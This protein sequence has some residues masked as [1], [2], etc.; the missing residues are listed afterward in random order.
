MWAMANAAMPAPLKALG[1]VFNSQPM[2]RREDRLKDAKT[3]AERC[4]RDLAR[5]RSALERKE[6]NLLAQVRYYATKGDYHKA[7]VGSVMIAT[8]A[9]LMVS[10]HKVSRAEIEALKGI[11]YANIEQDITSTRTKGFKYAQRMS[12]C[13]EIETTLNDGLDEVYED[14]ESSRKRREYFD[15][16]ADHPGGRFY[17]QPKQDSQAIVIHFRLYDPI[18]AARES[19]VGPSGENVDDVRQVRFPSVPSIPNL[20]RDKSSSSPTISP[21]NDLSALY[22]SLPPT[23]GS[24]TIPTLDLSVDMLKRLM[25]QDPYLLSQLSLSPPAITTAR[26]RALETALGMPASVP[27]VLGRL[28]NESFEMFD[29]VKSLKECGVRRGVRSDDEDA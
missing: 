26:S 29:F 18:A 17:I 23:G 12:E 2:A 10:N 24:F 11:R 13:E 5:D 20:S 14:A 4:C 8:R 6:K 19:V 7:K 27:F 28:V 3:N 25:L 21:L 15:L 9:Q 1:T 22:N 16:E